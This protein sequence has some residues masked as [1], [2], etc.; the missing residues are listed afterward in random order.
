M[1]AAFQ[2]RQAATYQV[3]KTHV[4]MECRKSYLL[5]SQLFLAVPNLKV[6]QLAIC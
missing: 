4:T 2:P 1:K 3:C 5:Y 6:N